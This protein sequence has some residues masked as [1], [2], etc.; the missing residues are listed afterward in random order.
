MP[1]LLTRQEVAEKL[2]ISTVTVDRLR[3]SGKLAYIQ[4][5]PNGKVWFTDDAVAEYIARSTHAALPARVVTETY[6]KRR[7]AS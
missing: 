1:E 3:K 5:T 6:R 4:H 7:V 2:G